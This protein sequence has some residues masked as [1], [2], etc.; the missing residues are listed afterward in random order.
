MTPL[1]VVIN[2]DPKTGQV[3]DFLWAEKEEPPPLIRPQVKKRPLAND[4]D[5]GKKKSKPS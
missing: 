2:V 1:K 5:Q 4:D 3:D